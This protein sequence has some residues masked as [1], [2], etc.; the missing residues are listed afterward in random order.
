MAKTNKQI[1]DEAEN[2][3]TWDIRLI[4]RS[5]LKLKRCPKCFKVDRFTT[6]CLDC[7]DKMQEFYAGTTC[8]TNYSKS[9]RVKAIQLH[10]AGASPKLISETLGKHIEYIRKILN[11]HKKARKPKKCSR[12][13]L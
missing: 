9:T 4:D 3:E 8:R 12:K 6:V 7:L 5:H 2:R 1:I 13:R 10:K 11:T